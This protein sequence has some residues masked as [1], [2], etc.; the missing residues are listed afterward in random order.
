MALTAHQGTG[1]LAFIS[2]ILVAALALLV[3]GSHQRYRI[4]LHRFC[5]AFSAALAFILI[6]VDAIVII[7]VMAGV[8]PDVFGMLLVGK[9]DQCTLMALQFRRVHRN[10]FILCVGRCN[11]YQQQ[12]YDYQQSHDHLYDLDTR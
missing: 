10:D 3:E 9:A 5:V 2:Q 4:R 6:C 8:A 7:V 12:V 11:D 1:G